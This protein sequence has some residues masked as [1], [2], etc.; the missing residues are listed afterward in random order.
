MA[1]PGV[2]GARRAQRRETLAR[3]Q[4]L[5]LACQRGPHARRP[6]GAGLRAGAHRPAVRIECYDISTIRATST[7]GS[8]VVFEEGRPRSASTAGSDGTV[9]GTDDFASAS[10]EVLRRRFRRARSRRGKRR[11]AALAAPGPGRS[12]TAARAGER[13]ARRAR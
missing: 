10:R 11:G 5:A 9:E 4:A 13:R 2:D 3:E 12:S 8:M 6:R 7:V 1:R